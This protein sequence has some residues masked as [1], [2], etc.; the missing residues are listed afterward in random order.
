MV[1]TGQGCGPQRAG[2]TRMKT[3]SVSAHHRHRCL[4]WLL[5]K[6][7]EPCPENLFLFEASCPN[8][9][10]QHALLERKTSC[11]ESGVKRGERDGLITKSHGDGQACSVFYFHAFVFSP[12]ICVPAQT[13]VLTRQTEASLTIKLRSTSASQFARFWTSHICNST[14]Y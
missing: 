14:S 13:P 5:M 12:L 9:I 8:L 7:P 6:N 11:S 2:L 1:G 3:L 10:N 4:E